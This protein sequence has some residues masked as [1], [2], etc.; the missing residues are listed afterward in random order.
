MKVEIYNAVAG[1]RLSRRRLLQSAAAIGA[2]A[3]VGM[4][5]AAQ[6]GGDLR[7]QLLQIPGVRKGAPTEADWRKVGE[8]CLGQTKENVAEGEFAGVELTFMGTNNQNLHN[9][10]FR[11]LLTA[12]E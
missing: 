2:L 7:A 3:G 12:W 9:I 5:A 11:G 1:K 4:P 6:S 10:L 8:M